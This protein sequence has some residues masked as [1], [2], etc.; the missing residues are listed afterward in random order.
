[1]HISPQG[2]DLI[3]DRTSSGPARWKKKGTDGREGE[4]DA[5]EVEGTSRNREKEMDMGTGEMA[6]EKAEE[7]KTTDNQ[8]DRK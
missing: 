4:L 6:E 5:P 7:N 1:M 8:G 2:W 3:L